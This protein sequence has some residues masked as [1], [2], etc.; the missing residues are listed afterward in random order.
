MF[1]IAAPAYVSLSPVLHI[2]YIPKWRELSS[3]IQSASLHE[4]ALD[5]VYIINLKIVPNMHQPQ[6]S[7][8]YREEKKTQ[9]FVI[10]WASRG[11]NWSEVLCCKAPP[12]L[13]G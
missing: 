8:H 10:N 11:L 6:L 5:R 7:R 12:P 9:V 13:N 3:K 2:H 1:A 4:L